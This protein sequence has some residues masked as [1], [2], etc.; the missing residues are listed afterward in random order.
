[1]EQVSFSVG[2]RRV[3]CRRAGSGEPVLYL[4]GFPTSSYLW[5]QE[6]V[7]AGF[8]AI[9]VDLPG[10]GD[11]D[12][13][14]RPHT[15]ESLVDW[16]DDFVGVA[17]IEPVHL[18]VHDWGGLIGIA[19]ACLHPAK[20]RSLLV[21][22]TSFRSTDR[23]HAL[24]VQWRTPGLG[25][26]M[27]GEMTEEGFRS[28]MAASGSIPIDAIAQFWKGLST[29]ERRLAK[30]EMY[31]SLEFEMLAPLEPRL[32]E[33]APGRA[34]VIWGARDPVLPTKIADRFGERLGAEV[35]HLDAGHFL[36]EERGEEVGR[37]HLEFLQSLA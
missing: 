9:A 29:P 34:R 6:A 24:A 30:L 33:V 14:D 15:W 23:W 10:F 27:I 7:G 31:R 5:R 2:G 11:S 8:A 18:C 1:M 37:L 16:L 13:M 35:T 4:H 3:E 28:F 32:A 22:D 26:Q 25:E 19:W 21:T 20:V 17:G 36:Q 12:L